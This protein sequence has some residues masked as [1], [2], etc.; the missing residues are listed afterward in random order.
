MPCPVSAGAAETAD[1][2]VARMR[3]VLFDFTIA[4]YIKNVAW[5]GG[6]RFFAEPLLDLRSSISL[7]ISSYSSTPESLSTMAVL[8]GQ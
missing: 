8:C 1:G 4:Y 5:R 6:Y 7:Q 3:M 2:A